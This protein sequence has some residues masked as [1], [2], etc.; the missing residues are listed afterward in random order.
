MPA[1]RL[2]LNAKRY[3]H[4]DWIQESHVPLECG[5]PVVSD[6]IVNGQDAVNGAWPWQASVQVD[7]Q[8]ICGGTIITN[9]WVL[10]AAHCYYGLNISQSSYS[11]CLGMYQLSNANQNSVCSP[12]KT[13][14]ANSLFTHPGTPGDIMLLELETTV[15]FTDFIMPACLP[16]SSVQFPS[17]LN[18]WVTGWGNIYSS[19]PLPEPMTLQQ[20]MVPLID[21][22][23]CDYL[24]HI[25]SPVNSTTPIILDDMICAGYAY[26]FQDSCQ[27]DSGGPLVCAADGGNWFLAGVVSWGDGCALAY[28]PGVYTLVTAYTEWIQQYVANVTFYQG[29]FH[30]ISTSMSTT[31]RRKP[32]TLPFTPP[33][34]TTMIFPIISSFVLP[35]LFLILLNTF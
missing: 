29:S 10:C 4:T 27:G 1:A 3:E 33:S 17:G 32:F 31:T 24:Y 21:Q 28:R 30:T 18:C 9:N 7:G 26:G 13:I 14:I 6:R 8:H 16:T 25:G 12:V 15:T 22:S 35:F 2:L 34:S 11:V 23:T 19:I 5:R 20:V